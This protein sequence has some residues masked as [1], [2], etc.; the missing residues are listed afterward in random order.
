VAEATMGKRE[1]REL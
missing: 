1:N